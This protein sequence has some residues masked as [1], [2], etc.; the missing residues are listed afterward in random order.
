MPYLPPHLRDGGGS[1]GSGSESDGGRGSRG[2]DRFDDRRGGGGGRYDDRRGGDRYDDRRRD[3]RYD[4]R[5]RG[6]GY[7]DRR[8]DDRDRYDDRRRDDRDRDSRS[9]GGGGSSSRSGVPPAVF[10]NWKPSE[11]V[12]ALSVNQ[13]RD[14]PHPTPRRA[15]RPRAAPSIA[16]APRA[17]PPRFFPRSRRRTLA[18]ATHLSHVTREQI[19]LLPPTLRNLR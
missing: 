19:C 13:V 9:G 15:G 6:D 1:G 4:D 11:R 5:R 10:A 12:Q 2:P 7:D 16:L 18:D 3:D 17:R 8:R 14:P